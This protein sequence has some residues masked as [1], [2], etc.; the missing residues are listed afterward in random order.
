MTTTNLDIS[1]EEWLIFNV[2]QMGKFLN[3]D[4]KENV[5]WRSFVTGYYRVNYDYQNWKLIIEQLLKDH[6]VIPVSNRAQILNDAFNLARADQLDYGTVLRLARYLKKEK[7]Y[8]PWKAAL[9]AFSFLNSM[10]QRTS[11][12]E[13]FKVISN[14]CCRPV[15][16]WEQDSSSIASENVICIGIAHLFI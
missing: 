8:L 12:Y 6:T 10:L 1:H 5:V 7:D 11:S 13:I 4:N 14:F 9:D 16:A 2:D 3:N 15:R